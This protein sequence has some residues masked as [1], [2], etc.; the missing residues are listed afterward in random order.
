MRNDRMDAVIMC[1]GLGA[2]LRPLT[3]SIPKPLVPVCGRSSLERILDALPQEVDRII[4]VIGYLGGMVRKRIGTGLDDREVV[5]VTQDVLDGTGGALRRARS[6]IQSERFIVLN[7]DDLYD[8]HDL[9]DL[10]QSEHAIMYAHRIM[11]AAVDG[12]IVGRDGFAKGIE[13]IE[14]GNTSR[15]NAGAYALTHAW[16][17]T[18][19]VLSPDKTSE[20]SVPHAIP[21]LIDRGYKVRALEARFWMPVGTPEELEKAERILAVTGTI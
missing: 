12:W 13:R 11:D 18:E 10:S 21:Q 14:S 7:G 8:A 1:A 5:Y 16:F 15:M 17:D 2:R 9:A 4:L 20:W 19:P 6:A 3:D